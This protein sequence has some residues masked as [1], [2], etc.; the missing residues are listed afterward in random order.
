MMSLQRLG[1]AARQVSLKARAVATTMTTTT[2]IISWRS[3]PC[4]VW[5]VVRPNATMASSAF[6]FRRSLA[7]TTTRQDRDPFQSILGETAP[8]EIVIG[9]VIDDGFILWKHGDA[10]Q[11]VTVTGPLIAAPDD[12]WTWEVTNSKDGQID[13]GHWNKQVLEVMRATEPRPELLV[14]GT[15]RQLRVL[16]PDTIAALKELG[17]SVEQLD[18]KQ[19]CSTFNILAEE[20]R[21][22]MAMLLPI[23][24]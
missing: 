11:K 4:P 18:T 6:L 5:P 9:K 2:P 17:V 8:P 3:R 15:G 22:V 12:A 1:T 24:L 14:L 19:A 23:T 13:T 16:T 7:T 10:E 20:G 21:D